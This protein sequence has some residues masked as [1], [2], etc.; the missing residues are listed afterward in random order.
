MTKSNVNSLSYRSPRRASFKATLIGL[1]RS[2]QKLSMNRQKSIPMKA[3]DMLRGRARHIALSILAQLTKAQT[4]KALKQNRVQNIYFHFLPEADVENFLELIRILARDHD[5]ISYSEA[6]ER[7]KAGKIDKPYLSISFDDG[8][9]SNRLAG[10]LLAQEGISACF[11]IC[12]DMV[13]KNR[14]ALEDEFSGELGNE[15]RMMTW[16]EIEELLALGHEIGSHTLDH[17]VLAALPLDEARRQV[18]KSKKVLDD[19]LGE[20]QH[21]AWPRGRFHHFRPELIDPVFRAGYDSCASA[22]RGAHMV[23]LSRDTGCIRRENCVADWPI[24]HTL[25]L[26]GRSVRK[27]STTA[28]EWPVEWSRKP[29]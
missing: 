11:F 23:V 18:I 21:F 3:K 29:V 7:V 24:R 19:R 4:Q 6:I 14:A 12:P 26:L 2:N 28:G 8:F 17:S 10:S 9:E 20:V 16:E 22:V 13:G 1:V 5:F 15:K 25:Y 27:L